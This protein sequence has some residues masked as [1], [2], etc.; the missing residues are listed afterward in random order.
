M[1]F[2]FGAYLLVVF[3]KSVIQP[4]AVLYHGV[5]PDTVADEID[6]D[7][8]IGPA[9]FTFEQMGHGSAAWY[10][11]QQDGAPGVVK[12]YRVVKPINVVVAKHWRD[13]GKDPDVM[14]ALGLEGEDDP[15]NTA[16]MTELAEAITELHGV[17]GWIL[18]EV[19]EVMIDDPEEYLEM[20]ITEA[21][22]GHTTSHTVGPMLGGDAQMGH[23]YGSM[24]GRFKPH[25]SPEGFPYDPEQEI[26]DMDEWEW[27]E[28]DERAEF[29]NKLGMY[30][31]T[32]PHKR[33]DMRSLFDDQQWGLAAG[34]ERKGNLVREYVQLVLED[35]FRLRP[36]S[37]EP[38]G[39]VNQ[40]GMRVPGGSQ[41]GWS[42][43]YYPSTEENEDPA[44]T[45]K[46]IMRK[47]KEREGEIDEDDEV[48]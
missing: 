28:P 18:T 15:T 19:K 32:D 13:F 24:A 26:E 45:L 34:Y 4:G 23:G 8:P 11:E 43:A 27:M 37:S 10:A 31:T 29:Q 42:S 12:A 38:G 17:D 20:I 30:H 35:I 14:D 6:Y 25:K 39:A 5:N 22:G 33:R 36:A 3:K 41:F 16:T 48:G 9:W 21:L 2:L 47:R 1:A 40:F 46:D 44:Y 7:Y